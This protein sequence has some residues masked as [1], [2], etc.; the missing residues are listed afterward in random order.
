LHPS[1]DRHD[2]PRWFASFGVLAGPPEVCDLL[3]EESNPLDV[4][5]VED[6]AVGGIIRLLGLWLGADFGTP[7]HDQETGQQALERSRAHKRG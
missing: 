7:T 6:A 2:G 5:Q 3:F 1:P 4:E